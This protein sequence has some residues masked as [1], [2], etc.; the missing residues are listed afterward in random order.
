ME[1]WSFNTMRACIQNNDY[2]IKSLGYLKT[3]AM[4]EN[5]FA[6]RIRN[7]RTF[8]LWN[9]ESLALESRKYSSR[10]RINHS[11]L[12]PGIQNPESNRSKTL[13]DYMRWI[14]V[15]LLDQKYSINR[16]S[17]A[18]SCAKSV[19]ILR[20]VSRK[21]ILLILIQGYFSSYFVINQY[22]ALLARRSS[23]ENTTRYSKQHVGK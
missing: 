11:S 20:S 4:E 22:Y 13:L 10:N 6:C 8:C 19:K 12:P 15:D 14:K 16:V 9:P 21:L 2:F 1:K 18:Y 17:T 23:F 5:L 3:H 7:Q